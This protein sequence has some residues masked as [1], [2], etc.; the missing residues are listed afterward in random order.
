MTV[1]IATFLIVGFC[2]MAVFF[3]SWLVI[4]H[5]EKY[6]HSHDESQVVIDEISGIYVTFLF[7][8]LSV[9]VFIAGFLLFRFF[10]QKKI[11]RATLR[12]RIVFFKFKC[13]WP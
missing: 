10:S 5:Y 11:S 3:L 8:T 12:F 13:E 6:S 2:F 9:P 7:A 1:L 4:W